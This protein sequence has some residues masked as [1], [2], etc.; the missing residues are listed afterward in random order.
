[1]EIVEIVESSLVV[2]SEETPKERQWLSNFDTTI[3][4]T[5]YTSLIYLYKFNGDPDFFSVPTIK[6]ALAKALVL[7]YPLAG[8]VAA[9]K[10]GRLEIDC[11]GEG[12][13][14][15]VARSELT[16]DDLKDYQPS[17]ENRKLFV[18][19]DN[20]ETPP[21]LMLQITFLE[22]RDVVLGA[23]FNHCIVD[24]HSDF[25][26]MQT[27]SS[28]ARGNAS[29]VPPPLLD[30]TLLRARDPPFFSLNHPEHLHV[31][32]LKSIGYTGLYPPFICTILKLS[33]DQIHHLKGNFCHGGSSDT[34]S[35]FQAVSAHIWKCLC[36][37]RNLAPDKESHLLFPV[38]VQSRIS[39]PLPKY[40]FGNICTCGLVS[41]KVSE[42]VEFIPQRIREAVHRIDDAFVR[43]SIDYLEVA[44]KESLSR[45]FGMTEYDLSISSWLSMPCYDADFGYGE[46]VFMT[47]TDTGIGGIAFLIK[48]PGKDQ[49]I[50]VLVG[51]EIETMKQFKAIFYDF[52]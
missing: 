40:Y 39:P 26:F 27:L 20:S 52:D 29:S 1:M 47:V 22:S 51:L 17:I 37:A 45:R 10:D 14:F 50:S 25:H 12:A 4:P 32:Y 31:E 46:P 15:V 11:N 2:P 8:R 7:F 42:V 49:G 48:N 13:L 24:A 19:V 18:P 33:K 6:A 36:L 38:Q 30:R 34:I 35:T 21:L 16:L 41:A 3:S 9:D 44:D 5:I 43:E 28:I 23:S